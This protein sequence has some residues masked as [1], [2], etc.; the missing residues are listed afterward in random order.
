VS[1]IARPLKK[2]DRLRSGSC[3]VFV[4]VDEH[5][6]VFLP[7]H[8]LFQPEADPP[9]S[10]AEPLAC[11]VIL[12]YFRETDFGWVPRSGRPAGRQVTSL[13][14]HHRP[15]WFSPAG[16]S[17]SVRKREDRKKKSGRLHSED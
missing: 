9:I 3:V 6:Y 14:P 15:N 17:C 11:F 1:I 12:P 5:D 13:I 4:P 8:C 16:L 2:A 7:A 10:V